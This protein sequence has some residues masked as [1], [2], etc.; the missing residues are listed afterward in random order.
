MQ[1]T[2][3]MA[4]R[5]AVFTAGDDAAAKD[6]VAGPL[7]DLGFEAFDAGALVQARIP[8]PYALVWINQAMLR[9]KG[10]KWAL[11]ALPNP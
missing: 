3:R 7:T 1:D 9:S 10:R 11:C 5:R 4:H 8:E 6:T 2:A